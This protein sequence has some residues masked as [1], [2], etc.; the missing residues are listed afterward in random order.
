MHVL[1]NMQMDNSQ[2]NISSA[3]RFPSNPRKISA[4][5]LEQLATHLEKF[6]DLGGV[7]Y[8]RNNKA[9]VGGNQRSTIFEGAT[10]TY[11]NPPVLPPKTVAIGFIQWKGNLYLYREVEFTVAE[12]REAC[13]AANNDGGEWDLEVFKAEWSKDELESFGFNTSDF[14]DLFPEDDE[15]NIAND[16]FQPT[17]SLDYLKF[18]GYRIPISE[19]EL[20]GLNQKADDYFSKH[21]TLLG[22]ASTLVESC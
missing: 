20:A 3:N 22:F 4:S 13:I 7:V 21:G 12:F 15:L 5:G 16:S 1:N 10:I 2:E 9:Y 14:D 11:I 6:G 19:V 18:G 17:A 8:C